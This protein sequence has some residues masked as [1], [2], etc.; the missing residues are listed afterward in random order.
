[1]AITQARSRSRCPGGLVRP[2]PRRSTRTGVNSAAS[3]RVDHQTRQRAKKL[4]AWGVITRANDDD[5]TSSDGVPFRSVTA[6]RRSFISRLRAVSSCLRSVTLW[7][8]NRDAMLTI[9]GLVPSKGRRVLSQGTR[10]RLQATPSRFESTRARLKATRCRFT[11][12]GLS[13]TRHRVTVERHELSVAGHAL[14]F[15]R[16]IAPLPIGRFPV[17]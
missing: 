12:H 9:R 5:H 8:P 6:W 3:S 7:P 16:H 10:S 15:A 13:G 17:R 11:R 4:H 2:P 14:P 1:M